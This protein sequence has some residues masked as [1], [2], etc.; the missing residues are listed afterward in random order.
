M[1]SH[2]EKL[3]RQLTPRRIIYCFLLLLALVA[4]Q[5]VC[6]FTSPDADH[7]MPASDFLRVETDLS[8]RQVHT[9][10]EG[11]DGYMWIGTERGLNRFDGHRYLQVF[12]TPDTCSLQNNDIMDVQPVIGHPDVMLVKTYC[13]TN[14]LF[15]DFT[16]RVLDGNNGLIRQYN[17]SLFV[18]FAGERLSVIA[19]DWCH[20]TRR[21]VRERPISTAFTSLQV[22]YDSCFWA[23]GSNSAEMFDIQLNHLKQTPLSYLGQYP[24]RRNDRE[25]WVLTSEGYQSMN[26]S[27]GTLSH[28]TETDYVNRHITP[29]EVQLSYLQDT[30]IILKERNLP[31]FK[32][33]DLD[34]LTLREEAFPEQEASQIGKVL[35]DSRQN[36]WCASRSLGFDVHFAR[37]SAFSETGPLSHFFANR[38]I[39]SLTKLADGRICLLLT[40]SKIYASDAHQGDI[41]ELDT[42]TLPFSTFTH[43]TSPDGGSLFIIGLSQAVECRVG[44]QGE[45]IVERQYKLPCASIHDICQDETGRLWAACSN[46]CYSIDPATGQYNSL[47]SQLT[48][49]NIA[50]RLSDGRIV[51]GSLSGGISVITPSTMTERHYDLPL[52]KPGLFSCR[53]LTEGRDGNL[54]IATIGMG[55]LELDLP[56]GE[57][58]RH[59]APNVCDDMSCL[60]A[61]PSDGTIWIGT[62]NGLSHFD[63]TSGQFITFYEADGVQGDEFFERCAIYGPD[64]TLVFGGKLGLT[65]FSPSQVTPQM[66]RQLK[67][68]QVLVGSRILSPGYRGHGYAFETDSDNEP[69]RITLPHDMES[70]RLCL[71]TLNF[72]D[73]SRPN[74]I[75]RLKG[76]DRDWQW[77]LTPDITYSQLLPGNYT[78]EIQS[79]DQNGNLLQALSFDIVVTPSWWQSWWLKYIIYPLFILGLLALAF[80]A[81]M[82]ALQRRRRIRDSLREKVA[83]RYASDM[84]MRFFTNMAHEFR[85]PLTLISGANGLISKAGRDEGEKHALDIITNNTRRLL[86]LV[87]QLLDFNKLEHDMIRLS[88][89]PV[90]VPT[91]IQ[92]LVQ[93]YQIGFSERHIALNVDLQGVSNPVWIDPDKYDKIIGNLLSNALKFTPKDGSVT[94][95]VHIEGDLMTT[96]VS[97][98][99]IGVPDNML[100]AIFERYYQTSEGAMKQNATGIGLCYC[101]GLARLHHGTIIA[102]HNTN[103]EQGT[104]FVLTLPIV[105]E[106]YQESEIN[107]TMAEAVFQSAEDASNAS[108]ESLETHIETPSEQ[109]EETAISDS[110]PTVLVVDDEPEVLNFLRLILSSNY[111]VLTQSSATEALAAM[112]QLKPDLIVSDVMMLGMDGLKFCQLL[113]EDVAYCH[114][115]VILLTAKASLDERIEGL[116]VGADAYVTKPFEPAYLLALIRSMLDNRQRVQHLLVS[117]V[118]VPKTET[119]SSL[120]PQ[121]ADFMQKFYDYMSEHLADAELDMEQLPRTMMMSR[122]KLYYK[123]KG[124]TGQTPNAFFKTYKLNRAAEMIREGKEKLSYIAELTGFCGSSHFAASFKKQFG[125]LPS[126]YATRQG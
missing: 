108:A 114:I 49:A 26:L 123:V 47:I 28:T 20:R 58:T 83:I 30:C 111:N 98:T 82:R 38:G 2:T 104:T 25:C 33:F 125:V 85:T 34:R 10:R 6:Y 43:L 67:L 126:E 106:A 100:E 116:N 5:A 91:I 19:V 24:L 79:H 45:L 12:A 89:Q 113:K 99:G 110:L 41:V 105:R 101:R 29:S 64:S 42:S 48:S 81:S 102:R 15:P 65:I 120:S 31:G 90:H 66:S 13:G 109:S 78:L 103:A 11:A 35:I 121:D 8:S 88:V 17:D 3:M 23:I 122:S 115:P 53:D 36:M 119:E 7:H 95:A 44:Q 96:E 118:S 54:W 55:L 70:L 74:I 124:L 80:S 84:N 46:G 97:D 77:A 93:L 63:P 75:Y 27:T 21:I 40:R 71:S 92:Q 76:F 72:G 50:K 60:L 112:T 52:D 57:V 69:Q 22:R 107:L 61:D 87:N 32:V 73:Y 56:T 39:T 86:R 94:I 9:L 51:F 14:L 16:S 4:I 62:L 59:R 1:T 18:S 37:R 68:S 117:T